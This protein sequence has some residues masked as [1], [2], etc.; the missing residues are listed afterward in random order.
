MPASLRAS[1]D[2]L[3]TRLAGGGAHHRGATPSQFERDRTAD[4]ARGPGDE[5]EFSG[6]AGHAFSP[7]AAS[8]AASE[9]ASS[10][11]SIFELGLAFDA[12]VEGREH[13]ARSALDERGDP[14]GQHR[15]HGVGPADGLEQLFLER[16]ADA[17]GRRMRAHVD[18]VDRGHVRQPHVDGGE[19]GGEAFGRAQ[20]QAAVRRH[21]DRQQH[22]ALGPTRFRGLDG[23]RH[24]GGVAGDHDLARRVEI[25]GLDHFA[26]GRLAAGGRKFGV[27]QAEDGSHRALPQRHGFLHHLAAETHDVE[28]GPEIHG[29]GADQGGVLAEAVTRHRHRPRTAAVDP[30]PPRGHAGCQHRGLGSLRRTEVR[31]RARLAQRPQVVAEHL[32]RF[33]EGRA[34]DGCGGG[35]VGQH[36]DGLR[37]LPWKDECEC[38]RRFSPAGRRA[39]GIVREVAGGLIIATRLPR[40]CA[41][42]ATGPPQ[43]HPGRHRCGPRGSRARPALRP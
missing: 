14:A 41:R 34:H 4:A 43:H 1:V 21:A 28:R 25:D 5:C 39:A 20:H 6:E 32:A 40:A 31:F 38:H 17:R 22:R 18:R 29:I 33:V 8:A 13:L 30:H 24:G 2:G 7:Q 12:A 3:G 26:L 11:A 19:L 42:A 16:L 10:S 9:A 15:A 35:E 36:A 27:I 37:T 23:T